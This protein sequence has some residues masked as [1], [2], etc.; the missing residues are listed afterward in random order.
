M[1]DYKAGM[2]D[3]DSTNDV[4]VLDPLT[5]GQIPLRRLLQQNPA[6]GKQA[7]ERYGIDPAR[8]K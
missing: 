1:G 6:A 5:G 8:F 7:L 4:K 2:W 3:G